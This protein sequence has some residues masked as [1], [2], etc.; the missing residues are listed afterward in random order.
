MPFLVAYLEKMNLANII[1]EHVTWEGDVALGTIIEVMVCNRLLNPKAQYKIGQWAQ[2][3]GACDYYDVTGEQLNDDRLG[4]ALEQIAKHAFT[5]QSQLILHLVKSFKLNV[6]NI[7]YDISNVELY[8]AYERQLNENA[9]KQAQLESDSASTD[10]ANPEDPGQDN[11][12]TVGIAD[13]RSH[14]E[15]ME[16][17]QTGSIWNQRRS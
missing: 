15:R 1:D 7:H 2:R 17:C 5:V 16:E 3:A 14:Q 11:L 8:G 10:G 12:A 4:R 9:A 6:S 13:V